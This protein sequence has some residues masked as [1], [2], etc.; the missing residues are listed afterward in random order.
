MLERSIKIYGVL[1]KELYS[2]N[3]GITHTPKSTTEPSSP[4][5]S[6]CSIPTP[7]VQSRK[8]HFW[9]NCPLLPAE[10][11]SPSRVQGLRPHSPH[12][13]SDLVRASAKSGH[14]KL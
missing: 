8:H 3:D 1:F 7:F 9:I 14:W 10:T 6:R 12:C 2:V 11:F 4:N 13:W 5:I